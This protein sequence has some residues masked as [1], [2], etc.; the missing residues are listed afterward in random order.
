MM[1]FSLPRSGYILLISIL[2]TGVI[3]SAVV[4]S[5]LLLGLSAN[6]GS[7]SIQQSSQSMALA[8]ACADYGLLQLFNNPGSSTGGGYTGNETLT[9]PE[10]TCK[11]LP[12]SGNASGY[13]FVCLESQVSNV[14]RRLELI[15]SQVRP[16]M[17]VY[18]WQEVLTFSLCPTT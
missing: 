3:A 6:Q 5:L 13:R 17:K 15:V 10:G 7:L 2:V 16:T 9:F 11:V 8:Q 12:V 18:S 1:R 4:S 14:T